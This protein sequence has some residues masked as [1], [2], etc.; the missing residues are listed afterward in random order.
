MN[1][2]SALRRELA[3]LAQKYAQSEALPH[4]LTYGEAPV[5]C[6]A[7]YEDGTRHGNFLR[8]SYATI[9]ANPAWNLRLAKVHTQGRHCLPRT[10]RGRWMEL[11]SCV[12]SDALLM[13]IFCYPSAL[14]SRKISALLGVDRG[15]TPCFGYKARVPLASGRF[16]RTE[17]D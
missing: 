16:D 6:F 10:E 13:N 7:P 12:S 2:A 15:H 17:I 4:C 3:V 1:F 8:Q 9:R 5:V 11:D 14:R